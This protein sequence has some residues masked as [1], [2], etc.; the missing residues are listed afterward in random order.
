MV[1][2]SHGVFC[3][4]KGRK[5]MLSAEERTREKEKRCCYEFRELI[6]KG[7]NHVTMQVYDS[8]WESPKE[9][10]VHVDNE[11]KGGAGHGCLN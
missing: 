3:W 1:C 10:T 2:L 4:Q 6:L 8:P 9:I 7:E 11:R 5:E